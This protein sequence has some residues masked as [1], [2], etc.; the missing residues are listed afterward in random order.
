MLTVRKCNDSPARVHSV[1]RLSIAEDSGKENIPNDHSVESKRTDTIG[2]AKMST[3]KIKNM[4]S[5]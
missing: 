1:F 2:I 3:C 4:R 5:S